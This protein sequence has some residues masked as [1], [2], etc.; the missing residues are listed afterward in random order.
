MEMEGTL[1]TGL[2]TKIEELAVVKYKGSFSIIEGKVKIICFEGDKDSG[3]EMTPITMTEI[4]GIEIPKVKV[5]LIGAEDGIIVEVSDIV[6][7]EEGE[8]GILISNT[9]IQGTNNRP[10][11]QIRIIIVH[12]PWDISTDTQS[13]MSNT[14]IP[15]NNNTSRKCRQLHR[16]KLQI[17]VNC[18]KVKAIMIINA[19]L[20]V[21]LWPVHKKH[22]IKVAHITIKILI[23]GSG[24]MATLITMTLMG[25]LFS[26]GGSRCH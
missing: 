19:N 2:I 25:N 16:D 21:I 9:M 4:T 8:D 26:S 17:S 14:H 7:R 20:Q 11:L 13:H 1:I 23:K 24:Q 15:S 22:L 5:I 10:N 6:I 18:V 3:M 12:H